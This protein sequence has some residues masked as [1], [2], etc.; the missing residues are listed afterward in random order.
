MPGFLN[1]DNAVFLRY[2]WLFP[3]IRPFLSEGHKKIFEE[4][5]IAVDG[6]AYRCHNCIK[7]L[8]VPN[9]SV[10][11]ILCSH[12]LEHVYK[13]QAAAIL[14]DFHRALVPGGTLHVVVPCLRYL[15]NE[16]VASTD[17]GA[18]N[19]FVEGTI[20]SVPK[21][22]S[23]RYRVME[24]NGAFGLQHRWMYDE[25]SIR[26]LIINSGFDI[27]PVNE[28]PS[29]NW[30]KQRNVKEIEIVGRRNDTLQC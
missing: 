28:T 15:V 23:L 14:A 8:P 3:I 18:A 16:Y 1:L 6:N 17:S 25:A 22:P 7:P 10:T 26:Q 24:L 29:K 19:R 21:R 12:F 20:L 4:Y 11:H 2:L 30:R 13:D 9:Q 27:I 5:K